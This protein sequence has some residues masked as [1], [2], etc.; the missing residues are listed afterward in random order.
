MWDIAICES[1]ENFVALLTEKLKEFYSG[2]EF[3]ITI[4]VY[5]NGQSFIDALNQ[6]QDL[7]FLNTQLSDMSG[8]VVAELL[9]LSRK[10]KNPVLIFMSD[11]EKGVFRSF[12]YQPFWYIRKDM[13]EDELN[14][15]LKR[16]WILDHRERSV[17]IR[18]KRSD[19]YIRVEDIIYIETQGHNLVFHCKDGD[20]R[21]RSRMA[22]Y[23]ERLKDYYFVHPAKSFLINCA[24]V[25]MFT[26]TVR[27][28]DGSIIPCSK[29]RCAEAKRMRQRYIDE[30]ER[31]L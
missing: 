27:M 16:L 9:L 17:H 12:F 11:Q 19:K 8:F 14:T 15:A 25:D 23:E 24:H 20:Y 21:F 4:H 29:A 1:D 26:N 31:C 18:Q 5:S 2:R 10:Q 13:L 30:V 3:E 7:I 28:K 6:P 22:V